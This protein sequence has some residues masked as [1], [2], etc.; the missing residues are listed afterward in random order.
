MAPMLASLGGGSV[1]GFQSMISGPEG[2]YT[3]PWDFEDTTSRTFSGTN[4]GTEIIGHNLGNQTLGT[5]DDFD[6]EFE[7]YSQTNMSSNQWILCNG[8][9][10]EFDGFMLGIYDAGGSPS[11]EGIAV[12]GG[13]IGGYGFNPMISIPYNQWTHV[14]LKCRFSSTVAS[15]RKIEL[16]QDGVLI[17]SD[18][19]YPAGTH[20]N[21]NYLYVGRGSASGTKA[22]P[23]WQQDGLYGSIKNIKIAK[24]VPFTTTTFPMGHFDTGV[25]NYNGG[26]AWF[27]AGYYGVD[28]GTRHQ[29]TEGTEIGSKRFRG[30]AMNTTSNH[31]FWMLVYEHTGGTIATPNQ[32]F[33]IKAGWRIDVVNHGSSTANI[34]TTALDTLNNAT[35]GGYSHP[36][37]FTVPAGK[38]YYMGWYSGS[39]GAGYGNGS[40]LY[41]GTNA[42]STYQGGGVP[43]PGG[44]GTG[45]DPNHTISYIAYAGSA[46]STAPTLG[47]VITMP[48][49]NQNQYMQMGL[50]V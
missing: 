5:M 41:Q 27:S 49:N 17:G 26:S 13:K 3:G 42:A 34:T 19:N 23:T 2:L 11:Y 43:E 40:A 6:I 45:Y 50:I 33:T 37:N 15:E 48:N 4:N 30:R 35:G 12:A 25:N 20:I 16:W 7:V 38:T 9:Y 14:Q 36:N 44:T 29:L 46:T 39:G 28:I 47:D 24:R 32:Q 22:N 8:P 31:S 1:K 10:T 21:W 18:N